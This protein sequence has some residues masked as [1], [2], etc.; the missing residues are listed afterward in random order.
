MIYQYDQALPLPTKDLY[1]TQVMQM[2]VAAAKDMYEKG[3]KRIDD[4]YKK[5]E[6]FY[7]PIAGATEDVYNTGV[8]RIKNIITDLYSK[9][10]DPIRSVEGRAAIAQAIRDTDVAKIN[11]R[12]QEAEFA[13]EYIKN[14]NVAILNGTY[15]P[16]V[17]RAINGKL[18][19]DWTAEDGYWRATSPVKYV[20]KE[21]M[22]A[23]LA[24]AMTPEFDP[25]LTAQRKDGFDYK[26]VSEDRLRK[27][28]DDNI[29]D[30]ITKGQMGQFYYDQA[31]K[32]T[33]DRD[34][35][36][37]LL[38]EQFFQMAKKH[39]KET[40]EA[41]PYATIKYR[42]D[43][44]IRAAKAEDALKHYYEDLQWDIDGDNKLNAEELEYKR[45][46]KEAQIKH[47]A[48]GKKTGDD[49]DIFDVTME[50]P[51][52]YERY[53]PAKAYDERIMTNSEKIAELGDGTY[54]VSKKDMNS[55]MQSGDIL[56][57][58]GKALNTNELGTSDYNRYLIPSGKLVYKKGKGYY[59]VCK[60]QTQN[61]KVD[62]NGNAEKD[63]KGNIIYQY[64]T[65]RVGG[66]ND[67]KVLV[68][69]K[70]RSYDKQK[71]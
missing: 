57:I 71:K 19:E 64:N 68:K 3:E 50:N 8:G 51:D 66:S 21:D 23:P 60:L 22:I 63:S 18:L 59:V 7:S 62:N 43:E 33:G 48:S 37:E 17:E 35:A 69:V 53:L 45:Q 40:R 54:S 25:I 4:F 30:I 26:T 24:E 52:T 13:K 55:L 20:S 5:Y 67:G 32:Q 28:I 61:P 15:D 58:N 34:S 9:G 41:N 65:A 29:D 70:R 27:M 38:K 12:K 14:R 11:A 46:Y 2:A 49:V 47:L 6:D 31:L 39:T 42:T 10:I 1:D 16:D 44:S 36:K 56:S